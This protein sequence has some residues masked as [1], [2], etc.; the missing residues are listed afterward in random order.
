[1]VIHDGHAFCYNVLQV[2]QELS[3]PLLILGTVTISVMVALGATS[4]VLCDVVDESNEIF[5]LDFECPVI[6]VQNR[7]TTV[8]MYVCVYVCV[9]VCGDMWHSVCEYVGYV[10]TLH[11]DMSFSA[12][13]GG[14]FVILCELFMLHAPGLSQS[15]SISAQKITIK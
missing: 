11:G 1:M 13:I 5:W 9:H 12:A 14:F 7:E 15:A 2:F 4:G 10:C 8:C 6:L 3:G